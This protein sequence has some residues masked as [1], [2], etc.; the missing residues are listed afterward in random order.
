MDGVR[1]RIAGFLSD[2]LGLDHF[3]D[4]RRT[5]I[6][7]RVENVDARRAYTWNDQIA[8]LDVRMGQVRAQARRARVPTEVV[9]LVTGVRHVHLADDVGIRC[10][11]WIDVDNR[12]AVGRLT[13][14]IKHRDIGES[15][16]WGFGR[17]PRR[18]IEAWIRFP[19]DHEILRVA[20]RT[21]NS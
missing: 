6:G 12:N 11:A 1:S 5:W 2:L 16:R 18:W 9:E 21:L 14:R 7:L 15:F 4:L 19:C 3:D 17:L 13:V 8:P 20:K 10:R